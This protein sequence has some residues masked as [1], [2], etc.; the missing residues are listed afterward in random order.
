M[1]RFRGVPKAFATRE[2]A[3]AFLRNSPGYV[4][5][6][7]SYL[8][9]YWPG[10]AADLG[11]GGALEQGALRA[12]SAKLRGVPT[13]PSALDVGIQVGK[14]LG[15]ATIRLGANAAP[16]TISPVTRTQVPA[17]IKG[18]SKTQREK[19]LETLLGKSVTNL[20]LHGDV[21][22]TWGQAAGL[23]IG[24]AGI[25][26]VG[27]GGEFA[28]EA[29]L[30]GKAARLSETGAAAIRL[31]RDGK[32][33]GTSLD[34][35]AGLY[36][37]RFGNVINADHARELFDPSLSAQ[38]THAAAS[39]VAKRAYERRLALPPARD[40]KVTFLAG[41]SGAGKSTVEATLVGR[42]VIYDTTMSKLDTATKAI[43]QALASGRRVE[44]NYVYAH[45]AEA[46]KR[47]LERTRVVVQPVL[48]QNHADSNRVIRQIAK[49]YKN[50][51]RVDVQVWDNPTGG[52]PRK[53]PLPDLPVLHYNEVSDA[54]RAALDEA[55]SS[56]RISAG[57]HSDFA[58]RTEGV[59][60]PLPA[61]PGDGAPDQGGH[62]SVPRGAGGETPPGG[63]GL[64]SESGQLD[65]AAF[66][67]KADAGSRTLTVNDL[68][69]QVGS[70]A[71]SRVTQAWIENPADRMSAA[72]MADGIVARMARR[73]MPTASAEAR[74][75]KYAGRSQRIEASRAWGAMQQSERALPREGSPEDIAHF[76]WAQ[77][78]PQMRDVSGLRA[79]RAKQAQNLE[80]LTSGKALKK[81]QAQEEAIKAQIGEW[82]GDGAP[83]ALMEELQAVRLEMADIPVKIEDLSQALARLDAVIADPPK[84]DP[85]IIKAVTRFSEERQR[86]L[87][88]AG[89]LKA[90]NS[91]P[92]KG[93]VA[94]WLDVQP[95]GQEAYVGHR[96]GRTRGSRS[97][98]LPGAVGT[99]RPTTPQ[100][101]RSMNRLV[102]ANTG[103]LRDSTRVAVDDWQAA[104]VYESA[105]QSRSDLGKMG[106]PFDG[107]LGDG[108]LLINPKGRP[109]PPQWK[110]DRLAEIADQGY[111]EEQIRQAAK[112]I[113]DTYMADPASAQEMLATA[114]EQGVQ[115]HELRVIDE[116]TAKRYFGQF[117]S[118]QRSN[119][120]GRAYDSAVDLAVAS[121]I[122][123]R[124]GYIPKNV[125]ANLI[126]ALP[127]QGVYLFANAPRA[128]QALSDPELL[129]RLVAEVGESGPTVAL[130]NEAAIA[131]AKGIPSKIAQAVGAVA[132]NPMR[133]AAFLHEA[134]AEGVI[135]KMSPVLDAEDRQALID[136]FDDPAKRPLLNDIRSRSVEAMADFSRLTPTQR[137]WSR[138]FL[139]IPGWL[140][141]GSRYP[142]HFA[143]THPGRAAAIAYVAAGEPGAPDQLKVNKPIGDYMA[144]GVANFN[145]GVDVGGGKVLR[146]GAISPVSTP[147]EVAQSVAQKDGRTFGD[148]TNPLAASLWNV[149]H[150]QLDSPTG[151][152]RTSLEKSVV[153][154]LT[155]LAP[156]Y[157]LAK[158]MATPP[159][160]PKYFPEDTSRLGRLK[161]E[162]GVIPIKVNRTE[163]GV[164][165][166]AYQRV[167]VERQ[168]VFDAAK[169]L[170]GIS[171]LPQ[172]L[173]DA[174]NAKA[175][176]EAA[177]A[178]AK[179]A[180]PDGGVDY[181]KA[182]Y[183]EEAKVAVSMG[184][185]TQADLDKLKAALAS[186][187]QADVER[188]RRSMQQTV[189]EDAYLS[190]I[191]EARQQLKDAGVELKHGN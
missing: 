102:L 103:R 123:A 130:G 188:W 185:A 184:L 104:Q 57:T 72:M 69:Q 145:A 40:G 189:W 136:L 47:A 93:L 83:H 175:K 46:M 31:S 28:S 68:T 86:I 108:E 56:G 174:Y 118:P 156:G 70:R 101:A 54:T 84:L 22:N 19:D 15:S 114:R 30:A 8:K 105:L 142:F 88:D 151:P 122:F 66:L 100:G 26:P 43:D 96:M 109:V 131:K 146:T 59:R 12:R 87:E 27:R 173:K 17:G 147:W 33:L 98:L 91:G 128:M 115:W 179:K 120:A 11:L 60:E 157:S 129:P 178:S 58:G 29:I 48:A 138:R 149:A 180:H 190:K 158:N 127:H 3:M 80:E 95:S 111:D 99:G 132:D 134:A 121:I 76:W 50:D 41:G 14:E 82:Q 171:E 124:I 18:Y 107:R 81:L 181:E 94:D 20:A 2:Q 74:V 35:A 183:L 177:R 150:S 53:M 166:K 9:T 32:L 63:S 119:V 45:P 7:S 137:K 90:E 61:R 39:A 78:P 117:T 85:K 5:R 141:A 13:G 37:S 38:Q 51:P 25:L 153:G 135:K 187:T 92:R 163:N 4:R 144:S 23:G 42:D 162:V 125:V 6:Q 71:R 49:R 106:R 36:D 75:A 139:V 140:W 143:A 152:Y 113:V 67:S 110:R 34:K 170:Y 73:I 52:E 112:D 1:Y 165:P 10:L 167:F 169:K 97:S 65:P 159:D 148:Y 55:L 77:L 21:P 24:A 116:K 89:V 182:A 79:V 64:A 168:E 160:K 154:N 161:R 126:M 172:S 44:I 133:I 186:A 155:R 176:I 16:G 62:G 164:R 191:R